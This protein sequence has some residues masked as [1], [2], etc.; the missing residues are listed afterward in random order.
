MMASAAY[1]SGRGLI[2]TYFSYFI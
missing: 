2:W 1:G